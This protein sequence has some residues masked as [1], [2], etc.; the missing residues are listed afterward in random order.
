MMH[1]F[2]QSRPEGR[3]WARVRNRYLAWKSGVKAGQHLAYAGQGESFPPVVDT[4]VQLL[5]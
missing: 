3:Q 4:L 2:F 1:A 5:F